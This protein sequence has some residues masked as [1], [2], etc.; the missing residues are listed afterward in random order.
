[1]SV[2]TKPIKVGDKVE[3]K[4]V[5]HMSDGSV[6]AVPGPADIT[7]TTAPN[8]I[9]TTP[10]GGGDVMATATTNGRVRLQHRVQLPDGHVLFSAAEHVVVGPAEVLSVETVVSGPIP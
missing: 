10:G 7:L 4:V 5:A 9:I 2:T 1:M 8:G 6:R 3:V